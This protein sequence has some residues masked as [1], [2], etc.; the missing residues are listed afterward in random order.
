MLLDGVQLL[1]DELIAQASGLAL[2]IEVNGPQLR[3][4]DVHATDNAVDVE[5]LAVDLGH[6]AQVGGV[7]TDPGG[8]S[9]DADRRGDRERESG[10][11]QAL[12]SQLVLPS[13]A[14]LPVKDR[15][16]SK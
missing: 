1:L 10:N 15:A 9:E 6:R 13:R 12:C 16:V 8:R 11:H 3:A 2:Q 5:R 14:M 4:N 7:V